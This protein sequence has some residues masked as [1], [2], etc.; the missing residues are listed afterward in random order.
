MAQACFYLILGS[1]TSVIATS[2]LER[3]ALIDAVKALTP[4]VEVGGSLAL[5]GPAACSGHPG[6]PWQPADEN[7]AGEEKA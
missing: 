3:L 4:P 2:I 5:G 6:R 1:P 7:T